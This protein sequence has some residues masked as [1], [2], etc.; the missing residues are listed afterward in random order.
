MK[1]ITNIPVAVVTNGSLLWDAEVRRSLAGADL[2]LPSLDAGDEALFELINRP[3][4][5]LSFSGVIDGL[6]AFVREFPGQV[7]LEVMLLAGINSI[8]AETAKIAKL[9]GRIKP[10]RL[11]LNSVFRPGAE[12]YAT[13]LTHERMQRIASGFPG[14]VDLICEPIQ[15]DGAADSLHLED[16]ADITALLQRRPCTIDDIAAG[17]DL[18]RAEVLK[19]I[20]RLV[21]EKK[22]EA[23]ATKHSI[24]YAM[25]R[26]MGA[27]GADSTQEGIHG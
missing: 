2:V 12:S 21:H 14:N 10:H 9:V 16:E 22:I 6:E 20:D 23:T 13:C 17:L 18:H 19:V 27:D 7:W 5:S 24:F 4:E 11:Q 26:G 15:M 25:A 1:S 8:E 3:H